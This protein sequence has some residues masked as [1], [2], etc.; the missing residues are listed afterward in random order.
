MPK[1]NSDILRWARETADLSLKEAA[2]SLNIHGRDEVTP[3]SRLEAIEAG[4]TDPGRPLLVKMASVYHRPLLT[5]YLTKAPRTGDRGRDFRVLPLDQPKSANALLDALIRN[6]QARQGLIRA[7]LEEDENFV[8]YQFVGSFEISD[9]PHAVAISIS[10]TLKLSLNEYRK[11]PSAHD[12]FNLLRNRTESAGIFVLLAGNLGTFHTNID[13]ETFRGYA[14]AD[15][16]APFVLINEHDSDAAWSFTLV[17]ELAHIWLG[18]TGI[19]GENAAGE[20]EQ[21]CNKVAGEFLLPV[22]E[23]KELDVWTN[24]KFEIA[25]ENISSFA[26]MRNVSCSMVAYKLF[27]EGRISRAMWHRLSNEFRDLWIDNRHRK[28]ER[29]KQKEGGPNYYVVRRHRLGLVMIDVVGGFLAEGALTTIKAAR[30]LGV[31][32]NNLMTLLEIPKAQGVGK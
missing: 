29:A 6:V 18:Q 4:L 32:P 24:T 7:V 12:A 1:I 16:I 3:E 15:D 27:L 22:E 9:N 19:S 13:L 28:Q 2:K 20:I 31:A 5:F 21:F 11:A 10:Q 8:R 25:F 14:L 30:V 26:S 23:L 17:H